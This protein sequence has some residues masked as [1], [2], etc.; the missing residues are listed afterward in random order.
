MKHIIEMYSTAFEH[1]G[2]SDKSVLTPKGRQ[3]TKYA[4]LF[5]VYLPES[6]SLLDFGCGLG[7]LV[8]FMKTHLP[9][10]KIEYTGADV[11]E[12]FINH[13]QRKFPE[14]SFKLIDS[15]NDLQ[16]KWDIV[17]LSGVFNIKYFD[18]LNR[19]QQYI[20]EVINHLFNY[21]TKQVLIVDFMHDI[22]D[23]QQSTAFH[24]NMPVLV[25]YISTNLS[26]RFD[27]VSSYMPYEFGVRIYK[28]NLI[29]GEE[30]YK[31][32]F[33]SMT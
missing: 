13:N 17:F 16:K 27:L 20:Y 5:P 23:F 22:V 4:N 10:S 2:D 15:H 6:F 7:R 32:Y 30:I 26:K 1:F 25:D 28:N 12:K 9:G 19:N 14:Q 18:D 31:M 8:E 24:Q 3:F 29:D 21:C 33:N 11:V